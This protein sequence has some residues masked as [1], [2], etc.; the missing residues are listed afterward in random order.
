MIFHLK[1]LYWRLF[2]ISLSCFLTFSFFFFYSQEFFY[3]LSIPF[4]KYNQGFFIYTSL[5]EAFFSYLKLSFFMTMY[6]NIPVVLFHLYFFLLPGFY[7]R[8]SSIFFNSVIGFLFMYV[9]SFFFCIFIFLPFSYEFFIEFHKETPNSPITLTLFT[10]IDEYLYFFFKSC[11]IISL[12]FQLPGGLFLLL[13]FNYLKLNFLLKQR[14]YFFLFALII[15]SLITPPDVIS[16]LLISIPLYLCF[17]T[18]I[19]FYFIYK[20]YSL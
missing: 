9:I 5:S 7:K 13:K 17:E 14:K 18:L 19:F 12:L 3:I 15:G 11:L 4:I 1:E 20:E 2:Y 8:E 16:L 10:K 6:I